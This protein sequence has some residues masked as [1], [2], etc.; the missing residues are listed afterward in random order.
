MVLC[1][2]FILLLLEFRY[3]E[4]EHV[5][6]FCEFVLIFENLLNTM[7]FR[8][9]NGCQVAENKGQKRRAVEFTLSLAALM[10]VV[11]EQPGCGLMQHVT[12]S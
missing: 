12:A 9:E 1:Y 8:V 3:S 11:K 10:A 2:K 7:Y 5:E 4:F 6:C